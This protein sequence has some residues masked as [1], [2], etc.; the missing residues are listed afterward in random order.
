MIFRAL[1]HRRVR[2][3]RVGRADRR[4]AALINDVVGL[5]V[6]GNSLAEGLAG[7]ELI[8]L[9]FLLV[10]DEGR[11]VLRG[12][13]GQGD[14]GIRGHAGDD[15]VAVADIHGGGAA[16]D[17]SAEVR[18]P[19][20]VIGQG[21]VELAVVAAGDEAAVEQHVHLVAVPVLAVLVIVPGAGAGADGLLIASVAVVHLRRGEG[22]I[23]MITIV[24]HLAD[25]LIA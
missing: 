9:V 5:V 25:L 6:D 20:R 2:G 17:G 21:V 7:V 10:Q 14:D 1:A 23:G 22:D 12:N 3:S 18:Q 19:V 4:H 13:A 24:L 8:M 16:R 11:G 15:D